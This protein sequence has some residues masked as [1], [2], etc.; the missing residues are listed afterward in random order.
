MLNS[1]RAYIDLIYRASKKYASWDP[2]IPVQVGDWG[3]M[4][5]GK[6]RLRLCFWRKTGIFLKEGNIF[7]DGKAEEYNIPTPVEYGQETAGGE[8]WVVSQNAQQVDV[9]AAVGGAT[10][11]LVQC[12]VNGAFKFSSGRG[13][14]LVMENDKMS[15]IDPPGSLR[16][17]LKDPSMRDAVIVS[18][19]HSCSS[20]ARMLTAQ[21]G[22]TVA[23]GLSVE[24]PVASVS[25]TANATWVRSGASG[26]FKSQ[27]NN[28]GERKF[29][30]LFRL[31]S[32]TEQ[33]T[34]T[35]FRGEED[36]DALSLPDAE[37]PWQATEAQTSAMEE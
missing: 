16:R 35:G 22:S 12:K 14:I 17:L 3:R 8:M 32:L 21:E 20:Y 33:A 36:P 2:E 6:R 10:P 4:T 29:Y 13:A 31:V 25:A 26:N 23:L 34:T 15:S 11:A 19:V 5:R 28:K 27:V 37:P 7:E 9:E 1:E 30:P 18:E 24:P